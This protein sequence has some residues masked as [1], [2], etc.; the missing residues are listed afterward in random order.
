MERLLSAR[1]VKN[2]ANDI[3]TTRAYM[4]RHGETADHDHDNYHL[5]YPGAVGRGIVAVTATRFRV[6]WVSASRKFD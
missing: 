6:A 3:A 1:R 4:P 2:C 5:G